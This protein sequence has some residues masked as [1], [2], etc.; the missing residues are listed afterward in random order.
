LKI[1]KV[2]PSAAEAIKNLKSGSTLLCGGFGLC[3]VPNTL[4]EAV[5]DN[6]SITGLTCVSNDAGLA[7]SGQ[8]VFGFRFRSYYKCSIPIIVFV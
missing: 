3:G 7:D 5:K 2:F 6:K 1:D 8:V 4:I